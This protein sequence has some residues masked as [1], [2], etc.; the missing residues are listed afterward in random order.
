[1]LNK[2]SV[3]IIAAAV[4]L[5]GGL[6]AFRRHLPFY[7]SLRSVGPVALVVTGRSAGCTLTSVMKVTERQDAQARTARQIAEASR[8]LEIDSDG[9][10][11]WDTPQG[12][13]WTPPGNGKEPLAFALSLE[14]NG[15]FDGRTARIQHGDIVLDCGAHVGVFTRKALAAGA[16]LVIAIEPVPA[17]LTCLRR[18]F[19]REI[20]DGRV[21]LHAEGVWD[22]A[23]VLPIHFDHTDSMRSSVVFRPT[24]PASDIN[25]RLTTIDAIVSQLKLS[26]VDYL[27]VHVEGAEMK[28][29]AGARQT[30]SSHKPRIAVTPFHMKDDQREIPA[31][32][33]SVRADY[34]MECGPCTR[35]YNQLRPEMLFFQ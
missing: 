30:I 20:A 16:K 27:K 5:C 23:E 10:E 3:R 13:F 31:F 11:L 21:V 34:S 24:G 33:R 18:T 29:I 8:R 35:E 17:N 15:F 14:E 28:A 19:A 22:K 2:R 7:S 6:F 1:M 25:A 26:R 32:I 4:V 9:F 12:R